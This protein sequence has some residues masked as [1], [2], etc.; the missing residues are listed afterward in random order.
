L[1]S[2]IEKERPSPSAG[3]EVASCVALERRPTQRGIVYASGQTKKGGLP[4]RRVAPWIAAARLRVDRLDFWQKRKAGCEKQSSCDFA[5]FLLHTNRRYAEQHL[6]HRCLFHR[7]LLFG[8]WFPFRVMFVICHLFP[9]IRDE[10]PENVSERLNFLTANHPPSPWS[11]RFRA[12][13]RSQ[14]SVGWQQ[15]TRI[16]PT[17]YAK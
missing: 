16:W 12:S 4:F 1:V 14:D 5:Q 6:F 13:S 3:V 11:F 2:R 7:C 10:V 8:F 15:M 9:E 17:K